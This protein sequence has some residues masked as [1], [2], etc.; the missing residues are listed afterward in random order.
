M[1][2]LSPIMA[3]PGLP[4]RQRMI[5][6]SVTAIGAF[7]VTGWIYTKFGFIQ[8][9][10]PLLISIFI[11]RRLLALAIG[12]KN[13]NLTDQYGVIP[14]REYTPNEQMK[15]LSEIETEYSHKRQMWGILS[16]VTVFIG[17]IAISLSVALA[18]VCFIVAS[19]CSIWYIRLRRLLQMVES[20][21]NELS[22]Q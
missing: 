20:R 3:V 10:L 21:T 18:L 5:F 16:I 9:F 7:S 14:D 6:W 15:I 13:A 8:G 12:E 19:Y 1:L 2:Y 17:I 4:V 22:Q 11:L